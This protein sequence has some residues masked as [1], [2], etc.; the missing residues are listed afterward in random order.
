LIEYAKWIYIIEHAKR[1][2]TISTNT[3]LTGIELIGGDK[4]TPSVLPHATA[5]EPTTPVI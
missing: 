4:Y 3:S 2:R 5:D 1:I